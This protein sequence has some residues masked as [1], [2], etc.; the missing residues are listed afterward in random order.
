[1]KKSELRKII[2]EELQNLKE[3]QYELYHPTYTSAID[4][5]LKY[6]ERSGYEMDSEEV[7]DIVG[8]QSRR[9]GRGKSTRVSIP[10][11]KNGKLQRKGLQIV[12]YAMD[13]DSRNPFELTTYIR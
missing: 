12:V 5:A 10:L 1:M 3:S 9:P 4:T 11:Y 13:T 7:A 2:R 6:A 8:L